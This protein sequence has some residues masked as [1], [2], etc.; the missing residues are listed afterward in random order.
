MTVVS[1]RH[2]A[3][4]FGHVRHF[5]EGLSEFGRQ[6]SLQ[7]ASQAETL[8]SR[9]GWHV[10]FILPPQWHGV[11]GDHAQYHALT[12][13]MRWPHRFCVDLD[14]WHGL[15]QHMRY[16]PPLNSRHNI[17]TVHDLNH[18]YAKNGLSQ[19]WQAVRLIRHLKRAEQLVAI[20]QYAADD[21]AKHL[22][23]LP[24]TVVIHNGA[25]DLSR[26]P[27]DPINELVGRR[28]MLHISRMSPSK[29]VSALVE[30]AAAW[31]EQLLVLAGPESA[32][33]E[34]HRQHAQRLNLQNLCIVT[35]V[36]EARKAWLYAHCEAFLF[37]S[38]MEGFGLPPIEAMYFGKPVIVARRTSLPEVCG[39]GAF[40]WDD[41]APEKMRKV[42]EQALRVHRQD[43]ATTQAHRYAWGTAA[44]KYLDLYAGLMG[45]R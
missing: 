6:L 15:H 11:F 17:V 40:Y 44:A 35:D 3:L 30:M 18:M 24:P 21:I 33:V 38:L 26:S 16:R 20:S 22:P 27:Q 43:R 23:G 39:E 31:P 25:A 28:F 8:K 9:H 37:P 5:N 19:W 34:K 4:Q 12:E 42:V 41:F 2:I 10:H 45:A 32:E 36:S 7:L 29:N 1:T 13:T 14:V